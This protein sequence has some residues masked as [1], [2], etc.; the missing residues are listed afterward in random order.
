MDKA[1]KHINIWC[2]YNTIWVGARNGNAAGCKPVA[3][4]IVGSSPTRPTKSEGSD[5]VMRT[6]QNETLRVLGK[7]LFQNPHKMN[8]IRCEYRRGFFHDS[9]NPRRVK[10]GDCSYG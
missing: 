9:Q 2:L 1:F 10:R 8:T 3:F 6:S 7:G 4:S 5:I